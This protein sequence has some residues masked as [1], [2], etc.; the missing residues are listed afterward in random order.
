MDALKTT[1]HFIAKMRAWIITILVRF[2]QLYEYIELTP[3]VF[4]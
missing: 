4:R 3:R 2:V 1:N